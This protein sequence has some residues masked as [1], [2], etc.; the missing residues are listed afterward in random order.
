MSKTYVVCQSKVTERVALIAEDEI[1]AREWVPNGQVI[2]VDNWK[3][4]REN[5]DESNL[6]KSPMG[7]DYYYA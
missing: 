4:A 2:V 3:E 7:G 5:V 1:D 6:Y